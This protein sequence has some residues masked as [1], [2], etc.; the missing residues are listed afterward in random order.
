MF[1]AKQ[2]WF[3]VTPTHPLFLFSS[4]EEGEVDTQAGYLIA[5]PST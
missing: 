4:Q 1:C 3:A 5:V 2:H